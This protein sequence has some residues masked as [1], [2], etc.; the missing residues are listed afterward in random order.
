MIDPDLLAAVAKEAGSPVVVETPSDGQAED[1]AF[2]RE[3]TGR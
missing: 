3:A 1:I 2:L